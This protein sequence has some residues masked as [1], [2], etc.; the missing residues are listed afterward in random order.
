MELSGWRTRAT[1]SITFIPN[2]QSYS[3]INGG[4][5]ARTPCIW[6][7]CT[8]PIAPPLLTVKRPV[9]SEHAYVTRACLLGPPASTAALQRSLRTMFTN[10]DGLNPERTERDSAAS[11]PLCSAC[12]PGGGSPS[13]WR[14]GAFFF[15]ARSV[16][17][18][19][20]LRQQ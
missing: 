13:W 8:P 4:L 1:E 11:H 6:N 2:C 5:T 15:P 18:L 20:R 12:Y 3:P 16:E 19:L 10:Q 7:H 9:R 14:M 17:R